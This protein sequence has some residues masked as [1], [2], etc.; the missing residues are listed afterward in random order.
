MSYLEE[1]AYVL[2]LVE[3]ALGVVEEAPES[4][5]DIFEEVL[6]CDVNFDLVRHAVQIEVIIIEKL[7][8][9]I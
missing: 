8:S 6:Y 2:L 9:V 3:R 7:V 1:K 5:Y 4:R